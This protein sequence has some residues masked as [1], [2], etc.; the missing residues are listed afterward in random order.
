MNSVWTIF[1]RELSS[2][3][4]QPIAYAIIVVFIITSLGLTFSFG[5]F[6]EFG[7]AS[8][9][10]SFFY[11]HPWILMFLAP[12]LGMR[13]WSEE[14]REGTVELLGTYPISMWSI[15]AGKY[16]AAIVVWTIAI[17][18]TFPIW[19]TVNWLGEPDNIAIISGY[20]GS[21][22]VCCTFIAITM[23]VSAFTRDQ[24]VC[25]IVSFLV[26]TGTVLIG[27]DDV[28]RV[29][30]QVASPDVADA[31]TSIGVLSHHGS[32]H[33]GAVRIQDLVWFASIILASLLGTSAIL[34]AKRA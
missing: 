22:L 15:I 5:N 6:F 27:F 28:T 11:W 14:L 18:L 19:I 31:M 1:K 16:L 10:Y 17:L 32:L 20:L 25:L 7:D 24:V 12:A 2:Y 21:I 9:R 4:S 33:G 23:L 8:L 29:A 30:Q 34:S 3:F 13:M 26:C